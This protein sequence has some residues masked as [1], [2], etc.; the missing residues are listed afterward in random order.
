M[1]SSLRA[2]ILLAALTATTLAL[3]VNG[4]ASYY[5]V[6][7]HN[8]QQVAHNLDAVV[9]G[10]SS[11][12]HEW[13]ASRSTMLN[14]MEEAISSNDPRIALRQLTTSGDFMATYL[15]LADSGET[16]FFNGW[17]PPADFDPRERPWYQ[18]AAAAQDTI[19]TAPYVDAQSG[20]LVVTSTGW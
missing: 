1:F 14:G 19:V 2:R 18:A 20:D 4:V 3:I 9:R 10:N 12:L 7:Q 16:I 5:T 8:T 13:M 17:E 15:S 11:A 6:Q